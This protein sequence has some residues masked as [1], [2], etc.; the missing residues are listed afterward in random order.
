M[1]NALLVILLA[2]VSAISAAQTEPDYSNNGKPANQI[3]EN[4]L[5]QGLWIYFYDSERTTVSSKGV[6]IDN[7]REGIWTDY[8][9]N[10]NPRSMITYKNNHQDGE[11]KLFYESGVLAE[12]GMWRFNRWVGVYKYY[13]PSGNLSYEWTFDDNGRRSGLQN[14]YYESGKLRLTG[15]WEQGKESGRIT[16]YYENG[17]VKTESDWF[18]GKS[19]GVMKEYAENGKLKAEYVFHDGIYDPTESRIYGKEKQNNPPT[20]DNRTVVKVEEEQNNNPE[21]AVYDKFTGSGYH[22]L[23][24]TQRRLVREGTFVNGLLVNGRRYYYNSKGEI[25]K[26]AVYENGRVVKVIEK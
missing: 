19:D 24:D 13:N 11:A 25:I 21:N 1:K 6:Y 8:Y 23:Y 18:D 14:Y 2:I 26:T 5:K 10:G 16:E 3:D 12:E 17:K 15:M 4:N 20:V 22:K 9:K 7:K